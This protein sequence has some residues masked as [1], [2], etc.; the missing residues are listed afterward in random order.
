MTHLYTFLSQINHKP[1]KDRE[2]VFYFNLYLLQFS[3]RV[4]SCDV[5][6]GERPGLCPQEMSGQYGLTEESH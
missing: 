3:E 2:Y 1:L 5:C 4:M 6:L